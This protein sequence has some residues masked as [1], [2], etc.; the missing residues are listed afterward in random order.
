MTETPAKVVGP[1]C[2]KSTRKAYRFHVRK[3]SVCVALARALYD[4]YEDRGAAHFPKA[5]KLKLMIDH[6]KPS[7]AAAAAYKLIED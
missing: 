4:V 6:G 1:T 5:R 7:A 2:H 3:A